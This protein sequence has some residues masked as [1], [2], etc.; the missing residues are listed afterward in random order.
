MK[1]YLGKAT[2]KALIINPTLDSITQ[3]EV[4]SAFYPYE[5]GGD[6]FRNLLT[7]EH[8][9]QS[10]DQLP[11]K[12]FIARGNLELHPIVQSLTYDYEL[13]TR[14]HQCRTTEKASNGILAIDGTDNTV[15][16][17][18]LKLLALNAES[19]LTGGDGTNFTVGDNDYSISGRAVLQGKTTGLFA[20]IFDIAV[21]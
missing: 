8:S 6:D 16:V 10:Y 17:F 19:E 4:V 18:G 21:R 14:F 13:K 2:E 3:I 5:S 20:S 12:S 11:D 15:F 7:Q 1:R 9:W